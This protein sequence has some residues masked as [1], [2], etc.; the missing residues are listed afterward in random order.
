EHT[1]EVDRS[2][3]RDLVG[4]SVGAA[5]ARIAP[6]TKNGKLEGLRLFGVRPSSIAGALGLKNG[7]VLEAV[8]NQKIESANT[9][10]G[11]YSQLDQLGTV[12]LAGTRGGKPLTLTLRLR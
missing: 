12:E 3:V 1:F 11:L 8:N 9:L 6:I 5:G 4:G 2:L 10:L 7:D